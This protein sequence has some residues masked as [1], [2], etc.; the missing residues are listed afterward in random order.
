[1]LTDVSESLLNY[2]LV[3]RFSDS[4]S[5]LAITEVAKL[6]LNSELYLL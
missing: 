6:V 1:M 4:K 2:Y 3:S 5:E